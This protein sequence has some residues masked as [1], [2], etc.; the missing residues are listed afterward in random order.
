NENYAQG[1]V[2]EDI[3][4]K[5]TS[6]GN[7][8]NLDDTATTTVTVKDDKDGTTVEINAT[9]IKTSTIDTDN[10]KN[11]PSFT[12]R[13][14]DGDGN[15]ADISVYKTNSE[16]GFGVLSKGENA[17]GGDEQVYTG[18]PHELGV[19]KNDS[20]KSE[21]IIV[22]FNNDVKSMDVAFSW[23]NDEEKARV[24]FY[25]GE[26]HVGYA[27]VSGGG[28]NAEVTYY[29]A[30]NTVLKTETI[31]GGSNTIDPAYKFELGDGTVFDR[32][33][34][35][36]IESGSDYL[37]HSIEYQE[38]V[39]GNSLDKGETAEVLLEIQTSNIPDPSK[40]DVANP[41]IAKVDV[42]GTI[43]NVKLDVNGYGTLKVETDGKT[44]L[45]AKVTEI[46]GG[47]Y[48]A[49]DVSGA[50]TGIYVGDIATKDNGNN[51]IDGTQ[52]NDV[53]VGDKG[54]ASTNV[55]SGTNYNIA[56]IVDTSGSMQYNLAGG[57][58]G[59]GNQNTQQYNNS[60]MK[61][62]KDALINFVNSIKDHDGIV[63]VTL[64][65][66]S[67][68]ASTA[69][70][71]YGLTSANAQ[72]LIDAIG[73]TRNDGLKATGGT[74][75]EAAFDKAI[76]WFNS[77]QITGQTEDFENLTYFLTDGKPTYYVK[78][79]GSNGGN[80]RSTTAT[81][82][83]EAIG[84]F[85]I[86]SEYSKVNAIGIGGG[87]EAEYLQFFD[88]TADNITTGSVSFSGTHT[89]T[90]VLGNFSTSNAGKL[91]SK[92]NWKDIGTGNNAG[93]ATID[94]TGSGDGR[95]LLIDDNNNNSSG[96]AVVASDSFTITNNN[97]TLSFNYTQSDRKSGDSFSWK[98]QSLNTNGTWTDVS[99]KSD[100]YNDNSTST[101]TANITNISKGE[102]RLVLTVDDGSRN[103]EYS[104]KVDNITI[105]ASVPNTVTGNVGEP[106][107]VHTAKDLTAALQGGSTTF[108]PEQLGDDEINGGV[109]NDIIFGDTINTDN[110]TWTGRD[111]VDHANYM[112][113]G[114][115]TLALEKYLALEK[116]VKPADMEQAKYDY[117][118]ENHDSLSKEGTRDGDDTITGGEGRD[119]I[120]GQG[121][122]DTI[123][124]DLNTNDGVEAGD[125]LIDGGTGFDTLILSGNNDIDFSKLTDVRIKNIEAID[126]KEGDH[127][128]TN[129][130][131]EDVLKMTDNKKELII[132]GD[133]E[134]SV[135]FKKND[136]W[137]LKTE[138]MGKVEGDKTFDVYTNSGD[139][140][141]QVKVE[142]PIS[143]GI[144]N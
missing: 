96:S 142:Q 141:V 78:D 62:T 107:I 41:P 64:V 79:D 57:D 85:N 66:F 16:D 81:E 73:T 11:N 55:V 109:G 115:G 18:N 103:G 105:S 69:K 44:D 98:L 9:I 60:R 37:I 38:V 138:N 117:M 102:Y 127:K 10:I 74:N 50:T 125:L 88:N 56:L 3:S 43:H 111:D 39:Q 126:L 15:N 28:S 82:M 144:T 121:G 123:I 19:N 119:I 68:G 97:T 40:Y 76:A 133:K 80:G 47:N 46:V 86:L 31:T 91:G 4:I 26:T 124:T 35:S 132:F 122:D 59:F 129:I 114:M 128:L 1:T 58:N 94:Y 23:R 95:S 135:T 71:I 87:I 25:D 6:G 120:Y 24:D 51:T 21:K 27:T 110:L 134:D 30:D 52:G 93:K 112:P 72:Q 20:S 75:Y 136:G 5:G 67:E 42:N 139:P 90:E 13:A 131:L 89:E 29:K 83:N 12:V 77:N 53:L 140:T 36:A 92:N 2:T 34:F 137:E 33:E 45:V 143:D 65:D 99:G 108:D 17:N 48:E 104:V 54:G 7:Y 49:V 113:K 22:E 14:K 118:K 32:A 100:S 106:T 130:S 63:N 70:T 8:E 116:G 84:K 61:L 101:R